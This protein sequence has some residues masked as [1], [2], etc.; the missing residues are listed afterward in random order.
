[1]DKHFQTPAEMQ[2]KAQLEIEDHNKKGNDKRW[3]LWNKKQFEV[4]Q[5]YVFSYTFRPVLGGFDC[6]TF[7]NSKLD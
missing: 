6:R 2:N 1:M 4:T 3:H 7:L 5:K